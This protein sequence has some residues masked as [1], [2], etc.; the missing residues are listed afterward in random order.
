VIL[1]MMRAGWQDDWWPLD[2][3]IED[4]AE[5]VL[6]AVEPGLFLVHGIYDPPWRLRD[7]RAFK[8]H[9][10][11]TRVLLPASTRLQV[12]RAQ[13]PL[14][15]RIV[16][17]HHEAEMLLVIGDREP[18]LDELIPEADASLSARDTRIRFKEI[19]ERR[20]TAPAAK[21]TLVLR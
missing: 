12:H 1:G 6:D 14:L 4:L 13:L 2:L 8:H 17:A 15:E 18:V 21:V 9:F 5:K 20:Y 10:L 3:P 11:R 7:V 16:D 19:V